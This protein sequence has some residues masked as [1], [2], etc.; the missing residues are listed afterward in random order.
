[1]HT[2]QPYDQQKLLI[3]KLGGEEIKVISK[4]GLPDWDQLLPSTELLAENVMLHTGDNVLLIGSHHGGL[5]SF[6]A[7]QL[8]D[9]TLSIMENSYLA[10]KMTNNTL[11]KNDNHDVNIIPCIDLPVDVHNY[12]HSVLIQTPK[13]RKLA[14]RW[15]VQAYNA[16]RDGGYCYVAGSNSLGIKSIIK[17]ASEIFGNSSILAYKKGNRITLQKKN[18]EAMPIPDWANEPGI[19]PGTWVEFS[20]LLSNYSFQIRSLPGIFSYD[21]L[22]DGTCMLLSICNI[23]K[24]AN[25]LDMGCGYGII[26]MYA[27]HQGAGWVDFVDSDLLA[28]AACKASIEK[29][30]ITNTTVIPGD[31]LSSIDAT[32]YDLILSNPPFHTGQSVDYQ[33]AEALIR[34]SFQ[35]LIPG[36]QIVI[37]ANKFIRYDYLIRQIF[38]NVSVLASSG[39]FHVLSGRKTS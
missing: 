30:Q 27:A 21:R 26:G 28:I 20:I 11:L 34:Q 1:M 29:N 32:K 13:S 3:F 12:Y 24:G 17:D 25:V 23:P 5:A 37:V 14:R 39:K 36:G 4:P 16:L 31:L 35:A 9:G 8:L 6:L 7:R 10:L 2:I 22:D 33:I 15:L 18:V 38:D 19:A